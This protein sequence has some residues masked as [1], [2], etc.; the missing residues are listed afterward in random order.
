MAYL[1][2]V[3]ISAACSRH[4][5]AGAGGSQ[6]RWLNSSISRSLALCNVSAEN[7]HETRRRCGC[8]GQVGF[9]PAILAFGTVVTLHC[10]PINERR[11]RETAQLLADRRQQAAGS[12]R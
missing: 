8:P 1:T 6:S 9:V 2:G 4:D 12:G 5:S 10:Y 11:R 7:A 3:A